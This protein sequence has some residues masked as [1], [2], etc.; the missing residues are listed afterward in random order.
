MA[1]PNIQEET[2]TPVEPKPKKG[3]L[4]ALLQKREAN[5]KTQAKDVEGSAVK[6]REEGSVDQNA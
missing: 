2:P 5:K 1:L 3:K 6:A 4:A